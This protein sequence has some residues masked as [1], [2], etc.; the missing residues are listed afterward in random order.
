M[1]RF[2][3]KTILVTG[4]TSGIGLATARRLM[5]EG[6]TVIVTGSRDTSITS[7]RGQLGERA[8]YIRND[9]GDR[10][11]A[12]A[13]AAAVKDIAPALDGAFLNAGFG[14]F[15][16]I[17]AVTADSFDAQYAVNVRGPLLHAQALAPMLKE[18]ASLLLN[19]SVAR[20]KGFA[21]MAVYASTK[22]AVRTLTR[23]LAREL[24]PRVRVNAVSPGPIVTGFFDRSGLPAEVVAEFGAAVQAQV[25][26]GR[27]GTADEVAAVA[28]F[29]LSGDASYVTGAEYAVD[30]GF[31]QL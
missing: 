26:M 7:A 16:P 28:A 12:A 6:A 17:G 11:G 25:P 10:D 4:G 8:H 9:A 1:Q 13:L 24:A 20:E 19:T 14:Q 22:G 18:G 29:L 5:S 15:A 3:S 27:F 21:N 30:G 23:V 31:G 2:Q